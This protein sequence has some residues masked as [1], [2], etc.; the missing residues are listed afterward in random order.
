MVPPPGSHTTHPDQSHY[1]A[2]ELSS[3]CQCIGSDRRRL[4]LFTFLLLPVHSADKTS[5]KVGMRSQGGV[6]NPLIYV[7]RTGV[8]WHFLTVLFSFLLLR[9]T[10]VLT[11]VTFFLIFLPLRTSTFLSRH[12]FTTIF[13]T[14]ILCTCYV[15]V[16]I[17]LRRF[18]L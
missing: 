5:Q 7:P 15:N 2:Y 12:L 10:S 4:S 1:R 6:R 14:T 16:H 11:L 13:I 8:T 3:S 9:N 17:L 18:V